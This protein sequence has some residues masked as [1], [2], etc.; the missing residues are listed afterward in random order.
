MKKHLPGTRSE[1][2][3]S[4]DPTEA[5]RTLLRRYMTALDRSDVDAV[6]ELLSE[7]VPD[8]RVA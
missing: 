4:A 7:D 1:W 8:R 5:E 2:A 6:A 3:P